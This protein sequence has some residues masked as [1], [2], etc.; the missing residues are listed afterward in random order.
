MVS[1]HPA[2]PNPST[3]KGGRVGGRTPTLSLLKNPL[4]LSSLHKQ[5]HQMLTCVWTWLWRPRLVLL[6][7]KI[8]NKKRH[9]NGGLE[10]KS[11]SGASEANRHLRAEEPS[12]RIWLASDNY[13]STKVL[14]SRRVSETL[15]KPKI[16]HM[17][18][19]MSPLTI[20][21]VQNGGFKM[22][23]LIKVLNKSDV[24]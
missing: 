12:G 24:V 9:K 18:R 1:P 14:N 8:Q 17:R 3:Q 5:Q 23:L 7:K 16:V 4:L 2:H 6:E 13:K 10:M 22:T 15:R 21:K 20:K 11:H 19:S